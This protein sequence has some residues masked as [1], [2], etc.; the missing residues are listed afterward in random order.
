[1]TT[2]ACLAALAAFGLGFGAGWITKR[3]WLLH[4]CSTLDSERRAW[5]ARCFRLTA[6]SQKLRLFADAAIR[7]ELRRR[8]S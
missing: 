1:V 5:R 3:G 7:S 6:Q 4:Q 8:R 2:L